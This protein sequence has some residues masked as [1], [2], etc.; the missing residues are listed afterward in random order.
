[1]LLLDEPLSALDEQTREG[2]CVELRRVHKELGTTTVH[3]SH[4]FE[5]TLM[6]ADKIGILHQGRVQQVG[7][8]EEVFQRPN[9]EFV[10]RFVRSENIL[11]GRAG[12]GALGLELTVGALSFFAAEGPEGEVCFTV[13]PED[14]ALS[15]KAPDGEPNALVG[16]V[17]RVVNR[18]ALIRID[19]DAGI[20]LVALMGRRAFQDS[21]L[22]VGGR[23]A[24]ATSIPRRCTYFGRRR[25][26]P[27]G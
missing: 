20:T 25:R 15:T 9:S 10:A 1:M 13:R 14:V 11:H 6:V 12:Q 19:V 22:T 16:T 4:N 2:L 24:R 5:E 3:V 17:M 23:G 18:G 26:S 27:N 7:T 8:P 21:G